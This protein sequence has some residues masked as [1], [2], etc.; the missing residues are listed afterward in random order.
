MFVQSEKRLDETIKSSESITSRAYK[1]LPIGLTMMVVSSGYIF[2]EKESQ[3]LFLA[4]LF[5]LSWSMISMFLIIRAIWP[6]AIHVLGS[7]PKQIFDEEFVDGFK[8]DQQFKV[9]ILI[10]SEDFQERIDFNDSSNKKRRELVNRSII[11]LSLIP[12][13]I[14]LSFVISFFLRDDLI[15]K[16]NF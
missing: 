10:Q 8:K 14:I 11:W 9:L 16:F 3:I 5:T 2:K 1:I 4:A 12:L 7:P 6:Y 15:S 13:S